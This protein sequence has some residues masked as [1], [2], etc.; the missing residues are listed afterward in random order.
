MLQRGQRTLACN[1]VVRPKYD[2]VHP[3]PSGGEQRLQLGLAGG[4]PFGGR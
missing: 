1:T 4:F 3:A 2:Y